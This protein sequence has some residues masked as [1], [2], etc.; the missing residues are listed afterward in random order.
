M[1]PKTTA[2]CCSLIALPL[3]LS[4]APQDPVRRG[5]EAAP[6][7]ARLRELEA[8]VRR[9]TERAERAED[10]LKA[11]RTQLEECLDLL[12]NSTERRSHNCAPS[13]SLITY[14]QWMD[15]RGHAERAARM[16]DR[17]VEG[18]G[19][20]P[21]RINALAWNLMTDEETMGDYD[22]TA[23]ALVERLRAAGGDLPHRH[24]DTAALALFLNARIDEAIAVARQAVDQSS[25]NSDYRRR[26]RMYEA[27][28][29]AARTAAREATA[30]VAAGGD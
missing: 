18:V 27:A 11:V 19:Q 24:L 7:D 25:E 29:T 8:E 10:A 9:A 12:E 15:Q 3:F 1:F 4:A 16:L 30:G 22:R 5:S 26:L 17:I 2:L 14:H 23:L 6:S 21:N 13:R 20:D 28:R